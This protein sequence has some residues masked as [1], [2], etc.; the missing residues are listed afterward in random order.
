MQPELKQRLMELDNPLVRLELVSDLLARTGIAEVVRYSFHSAET[1]AGRLKWRVARATACASIFSPMSDD[2]DLP[3]L[4]PC[5]RRQPA[6]RRAPRKA[7]G[8]ARRAGRRQGRR[9]P[10][11]LQAGRPRRG[12]ASRRTATRPPK[13]SKPK[14]IAVSV[15]GRMMLKRVMGKASF[16]TA[17]GRDRPHPALRHARRR[18][19]GSLRRIQALGPGRHRRRR[20]HGVQDRA[21]ASCRS[22]SRSCAC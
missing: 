16:A 8:A 10:E 17:A 22:R 13:C 6:D 15:A 14:P 20:R 5:H 1:R 18:R 7:E 12:T 11:R 21:P 2:S 9:V 19:R 4:R 3:R